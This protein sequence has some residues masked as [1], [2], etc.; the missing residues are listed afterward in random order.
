[1]GVSESWW[2]S[3]L[4]H[5]QYVP[6]RMDM[7]KYSNKSSNMAW[8][9]SCCSVNVALAPLLVS[10][11]VQANELCE[12]TLSNM[13]TRRSGR[14]LETYQATRALVEASTP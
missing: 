6:T 7:D 11:A 10:L 3:G 5:V 13:R 14:R 4:D 2:E 8:L 1:M 9:V 12:G